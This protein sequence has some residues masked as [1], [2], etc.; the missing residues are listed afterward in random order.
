MVAAGVVDGEVADQVVVDEDAGVGAVGDDGGGVRDVAGAD[1]DDDVVDEDAA[2]VGDGGGAGFG[3]GRVLEWTMVGRAR[4]V[5]W[6]RSI[7]I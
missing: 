7:G 4:R 6:N 1:R 5:V 3:V 2:S